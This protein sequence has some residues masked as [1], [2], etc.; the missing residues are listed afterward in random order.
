[1]EIWSFEFKM[2]IKEVQE[3]VKI[4]KSYKS[5]SMNLVANLELER[6]DQLNLNSMEIV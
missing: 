1:M 2:K 4:S 5:Y 3:G 6:L